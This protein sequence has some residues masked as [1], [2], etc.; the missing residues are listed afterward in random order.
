M[1]DRDKVEENDRYLSDARIEKLSVY[2]RKLDQSKNDQNVSGNKSVLLLRA[3]G[4]R[5]LNVTDEKQNAEVT[6][7]K[8]K[9]E[10]LV[11]RLEEKLRPR[12]DSTGCSKYKMSFCINCNKE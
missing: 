5:K 9:V 2:L 4:V 1:A 12:R 7:E 3:K 11:T 8:R 6:L 10:K